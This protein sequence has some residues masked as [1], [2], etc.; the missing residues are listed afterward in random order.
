MQ[1]NQLYGKFLT[2]VHMG[3]NYFE[4]RGATL[5]CMNNKTWYFQNKKV[6]TSF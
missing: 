6:D 5:V 3:H 2:N 4:F 1:N